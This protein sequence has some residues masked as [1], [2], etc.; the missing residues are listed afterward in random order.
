LITRLIFG[1][2]YRLKI[3]VIYSSLPPCYLAPF[4]PKR[5]LQCRILERHRLMLFPQCERPQII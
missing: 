5:L 2:V 1:K 3:L 4:T